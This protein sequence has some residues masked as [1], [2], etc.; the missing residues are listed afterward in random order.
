MKEEVDFT[1]NGVG[2]VS[3]SKIYKKSR[4]KSTKKKPPTLENPE[5]SNLIFGKILEVGKI[6]VVPHQLVS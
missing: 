3:S 5:G 1:G 2:E 6:L 4:T